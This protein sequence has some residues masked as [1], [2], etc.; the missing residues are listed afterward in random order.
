M[1]FIIFHLDLTAPLRL[2]DRHLHGF[3]HRIRIHDNMTFRITRS[4][5]DRLDQRCLRTQES[6][7][8]RIQDRHKRD[9]RDIKALTEKVDP[10]KHIKHIQT[11]VADDLRTFQCIH[12]GV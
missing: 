9:L 10:D 7:F 6:F 4:T 12:I 5:P 3:S 1:L 2:V 11:H 8:I